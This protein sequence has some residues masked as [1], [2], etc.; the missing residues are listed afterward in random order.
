MVNAYLVVGP[1]SSGTRLLSKVLMSAGCLGSDQHSQEWDD[2]KFPLPEKPIVFR[3]SLPH[4]RQWPDIG[5]IIT[6]MRNAGYNV[7]VLVTTR[8][9]HPVIQSQLA[10]TN[11][12]GYPRILEHI[13]K[14]YTMIMVEVNKLHAPFT[15]SSYESLTSNSK[16]VNE[17]LTFIGLPA[18]SI[19]QQEEL[20]LYDG[21]KKWFS[22]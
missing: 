19:D 12:F 10:S 13:R 18:L 14:A 3:R 6:K 22:N 4:D 2:L 21:N 8:D 16:S 17:L 7:H 1:E 5:E 11:H 20:K 15:M 9:W